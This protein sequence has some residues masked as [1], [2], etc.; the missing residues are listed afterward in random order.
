VEGEKGI[1]F[2]LRLVVAVPPE[3]CSG[4]LYLSI[5]VVL[6]PGFTY[7]S[8]LWARAVIVKRGDVPQSTTEPNTDATR[9]VKAK[10]NFI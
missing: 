10:I 7:V 6:S 2:K 5:K 4:V 3:I 1:P 8:G 9:V